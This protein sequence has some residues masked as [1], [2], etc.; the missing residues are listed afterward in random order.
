MNKTENLFLMPDA[1]LLP[2]IF[3][4]VPWAE[5][6]PDAAVWSAVAAHLPSA[7][8][9]AVAPSGKIVYCNPA[10][11]RLLRLVVENS[12]RAPCEA[13]AWEHFLHPNGQ[14]CKPEEHPMMRALGQGSET[15][16]QE[17][18]YR[19]E[20]SLLSYVSIN[21]APLRNPQGE[22]VAAIATLDN[23]SARRQ[24]ETD[25]RQ[26]CENLQDS[27]EALQ[28]TQ[29]DLLI[30]RA[31][32][33]KERQSYQELF[34]FAT[35]GYLV[36]D[37]NGVIREANSAAYNR[38]NLS[39]GYVR[40]KILANYISPE[41]R[42]GFRALLNRMDGEQGR[43]EWEGSLLPRNNE[44]RDVQLTVAAR[45]EK[46]TH[47]FTELRWL[48]RDITQRRELERARQADLERLLEQEHRVGVQEER[49][50]I[51]QEFHDTLAQ[52]FTGI[53]FLLSTAAH[54][55]P[56]A[57]EQARLQ[58][59]RARQ[60]AAQSIQE[61]RQAIR[62]MRSPLLEGDNLPAAFVLLVEQ[63][64][65]TSGLRA[66]FEMKGTA[67]ALPP[68]VT[69]DLLRIGQ[70]AIT[71]AIKHSHAGEIKLCLEYRKDQIQL[72]IADDGQ[73]FHPDAAKPEAGFGLVGM[74]ERARRINGQFGNRIGKRRG[75]KNHRHCPPPVGLAL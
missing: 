17:M 26:R 55:L 58:I 44:R 7:L 9:I 56:D 66:Q 50:R 64:T 73:G 67:R 62:A 21:A 39:S 37:M 15:H 3:N 45:R 8:L 35:D 46:D 22:I 4:Q 10:A 18:L 47:R 11:R 34:E 75:H 65:A 74:R 13:Y 48:L 12:R 54:A 70:E 14:A 31:E 42:G 23:I 28:V 69:S 1:A 16:Q 51:A 25:L 20:D 19:H 36:T 33:E 49:A 27:M 61:A 30:M 63:T 41:D 53:S 29:E 24:R 40:G 2:A 32:L 60:V 72:R 5:A 52:G 71:N 59:E 38:L 43:L 68:Q 57:P 6:E